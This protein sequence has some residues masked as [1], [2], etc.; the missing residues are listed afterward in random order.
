MTFAKGDVLTYIGHTDA[1]KE[2]CGWP[3]CAPGKECLWEMR[4]G[5]KATVLED[6]RG[7]ALKVDFEDEPRYYGMGVVFIRFRA[8]VSQERTKP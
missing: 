1:C 7:S 2:E 5:K 6:T 3:C 4:I 8:H